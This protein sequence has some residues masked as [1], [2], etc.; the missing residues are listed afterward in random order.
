LTANDEDIMNFVVQRD[1]LYKPLQLVTCVIEK[2]QTMP[3]LSNVLLRLVNNQL[4]I[5]GTDLESELVATIP[6][7]SQILPVEANQVLDSAA[8]NLRNEG[9]KAILITLPGKKLLDICRVLTEGS[10]LTIRQDGAKI[11]VKSDPARFVLTTLPAD[12]YPN[13]DWEREQSIFEFSVR[14]NDLRDIIEST[15]F[16]MAQQDSRQYLNGMLIEIKDGM[17]WV[18]ASDGHRL[19]LN[20]IKSV[21]DAFARII[22]PRKA[23]T[24]LLRL[25]SSIDDEVKIAISNNHIRVTWPKF[26]FTSKLIDSKFPDYN[27]TIPRDGTKIVIIDSY[28]FKEAL[29]RIAV[30]SN[31]ICHGV[32]LSIK[33]KTLHLYARNQEHEEA[34][35]IIPIEYSHE[36]I[37]TNFNIRYLLDIFTNIKSSKVSI[38]FKDSVSSAV[39]EEIDSERNN[40]YVVMPLCV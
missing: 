11:I 9:A 37:I 26:T 30:I 21:N 8:L 6:L 4:S 28:T 10:E 19:A 16:A 39:I 13:I 25:L 24:E 20:G 22:L 36:P 29:E 27:R 33:S 31:D 14:Q 12:N 35:E 23:V 34:E 17:I 32:Q 7:P 2:H 18:A 15:Q 1:E 40:L 3:I 38:R 5:T